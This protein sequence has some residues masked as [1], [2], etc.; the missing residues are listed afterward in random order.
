MTT[1]NRFAV[2]ESNSGFVWGVVDAESALAACAAVDA[3]AG[4]MHEAGEYES[5]SVSE[6]QTNRGVYDVRIAPAG[7]DVLD[8]QDQ[9][10][11]AAV[12]ALP[13]AGVFG[14]VSAE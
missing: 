11:V 3:D 6:L 8:G 2:L 9:D 7:F 13:R 4:G 1:T 12:E 5:V 14:W 10:A